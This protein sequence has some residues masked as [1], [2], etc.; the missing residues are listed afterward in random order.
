MFLR[1]QASGFGGARPAQLLRSLQSRAAVTGGS[2]LVDRDGRLGGALTLPDASL[3]C[4]LCGKFA[5]CSCALGKQHIRRDDSKRKK[6]SSDQYPHLL[7][8]PECATRMSRG[9]AHVEALLMLEGSPF[10]P[11][12]QIAAKAGVFMLKSYQWTSAE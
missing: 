7:Q 10:R 6:G 9:S 11:R 5:L 12:R 2:R 8:A 3:G 1:E 4:R